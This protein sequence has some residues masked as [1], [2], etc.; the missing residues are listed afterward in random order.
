[1]ICPICYKFQTRD[2]PICGVCDVWVEQVG[3]SEEED[4]DL[5]LFLKNLEWRLMEYASDW[6]RDDVF[7][8]IPA[9]GE[10]WQPGEGK[11]NLKWCDRCKRWFALSPSAVGC[12]DCGLE[13]R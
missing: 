11:A 2:K 9:I 1:M 4:V 12:P 3:Q 8:F 5:K 7:W 6:P 10:T 13:L